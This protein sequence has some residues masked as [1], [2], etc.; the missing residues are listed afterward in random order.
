MAQMCLEERVECAP[1]CVGDMDEPSDM[2]PPGDVIEPDGE[3]IPL[4]DEGRRHVT[5]KSNM[6]QLM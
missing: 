6:E 4:G 1:G 5:N 3:P 2:P